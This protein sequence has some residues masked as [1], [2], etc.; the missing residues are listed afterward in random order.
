MRA[1]VNALSTCRDGSLHERFFLDLLQ[2][3]FSEDEAR[4]QMDIAIDWGRYG[5]LFDFDANTGELHLE[6]P[7]VDEDGAP[8]HELDV[9]GQQLVRSG[10]GEDRSQQD[11]E[12]SEEHVHGSVPGH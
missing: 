5:E 2:R 7:L 3:G 1:I 10:H 8:R 4:A 11:L 6:V 9:G 12:H